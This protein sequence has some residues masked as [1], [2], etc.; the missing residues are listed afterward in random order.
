MVGHVGKK[1]N[2]EVTGGE[3]ALLEGS[4]TKCGHFPHHVPLGP[5]GAWQLLVLE[6]EGR[7]GEAMTTDETKA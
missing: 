2:G 7:R 3:C 4:T 6:S 5:G 1:L